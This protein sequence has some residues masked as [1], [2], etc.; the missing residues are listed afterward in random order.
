M[1]LLLAAG[2]KDEY[3]DSALAGRVESLE[4]RMAA[5]EDLCERMNTNIGALQ[6]VVSALQGHDYVT[7]VVPVKQGSETVGYTITFGQAAPITIYNGED[8]EQGAPGEKGEDGYTPAIGVKQDTDGVYYWTVDGKWLTDEAGNKVKAVGSDGKEGEKGEQGEQGE[9]GQQ[10]EPGTAGRDGVTPQL[11]I[12]NDYWYISYDNGASWT[13]LGK[14]TGA[15]GD[16]MFKEVTYDENFVY[17]TLAE[18]TTLTLPLTCKLDIVFAETEGIACLPGG[19]VKLAYT[20]TGG[21]E[22]TKV[23]CVGDG[24]WQTKVSGGLEGTLM[25]TAPNPMTEGKVLVFATNGAG[26]VVMKA[27]T[28]TEG[29]LSTVTDAYEVEA[30]G[31]TVEVE[32]TTNMEYEVYIPEHAKEWVTLGPETRAEMRTDVL[33]FTIAKNQMNYQRTATIEV[34]DAIGKSIESFSITQDY[35]PEFALIPFAD[36]Q[37][38]QACVEHYDTNGDGELS[39]QEAANVTDL[40]GLFDNARVSSITSFDEF[41]YFTGVK[42]IPDKFFGGFAQMQSIYFPEGLETIGTFAFQLCENLKVVYLAPGIKTIGG[43]AFWK[44]S[45]LKYTNLPNSI[46]FIDE[47]AYKECSSLET[48]QLPEGIETLGFSAFCDCSSLKNVTF[49]KNM[50]S[51]GGWVFTRCTSIETIRIPAN[52]NRIGA[53]TFINCENLKTVYCESSTPPECYMNTFTNSNPEILYVP[54]G[55]KEL[56]EVA[57][58]WKDFPEIIEMDFSANN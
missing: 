28:F 20:V 25:V 39:M 43:W 19:S 7:G 6:T 18:G 49:S 54:T 3:D 16:A 2:C 53:F 15:D 42:E 50:T 8:G 38:K 12:E 48:I 17:F 44:C 55:S 35:S 24:G 57:E 52:I 27:L 37:V 13:Q 10:G 31:G 29:V 41:R 47:Y 33:R 56:Y 9:Q 58:G 1:F 45:N 36:E 14:A 4:Q 30:E 5:M 40:T 21:D 11:K 22:G 51:I 46:T 34:K 32:I 23:E 26:Q